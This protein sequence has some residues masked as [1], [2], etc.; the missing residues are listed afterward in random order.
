M[1]SA[2]KFEELPSSSCLDLHF[3]TVLGAIIK[4]KQYSGK[5]KKYIE[6]IFAVFALLWK[7]ETINETSAPTILKSEIRP[8]AQVE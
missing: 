8:W 2:K 6:Y 1:L 5:C 7:V 4:C 3:S